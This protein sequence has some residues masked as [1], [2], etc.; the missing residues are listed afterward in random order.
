V[1]PLAVPLLPR[2]L[3]HVTRVT[4]T[5]SVA[6]P[7]RDANAGPERRARTAVTD[8]VRGASSLAGEPGVDGSDS[9]RDLRAGEA[10][11][12]NAAPGQASRAAF[13]RGSG[14]SHPDGV[15]DASL[16]WRCT[17]EDCR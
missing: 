15:Q 13:R 12:R 5:L 10:T 8:T 1:V 6:V 16:P 11:E 2:L 3:D 17:K 14:W 4:A 9:V 7:A